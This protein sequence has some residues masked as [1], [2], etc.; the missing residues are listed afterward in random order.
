MYINDLPTTL[1]EA[2]AQLAT[3]EN[4]RDYYMELCYKLKE[5]NQKLKSRVTI[6][7]KKGK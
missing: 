3:T 1:D 6:L 5:E 7:T 4:T 2:L